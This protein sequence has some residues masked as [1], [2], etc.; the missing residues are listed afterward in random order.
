MRVL[1]V[2]QPW[3]DLIISGKKI[4]EIRTRKT[5]IREQIAIYASRTKPSKEDVKWLEQE[6]GYN[7][8][9]FTRG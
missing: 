1:A 6:F 5:N 7:F 8:D 9:D 4:I 2:K 3:A